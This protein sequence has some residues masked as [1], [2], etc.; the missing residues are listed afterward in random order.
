MRTGKE[1]YALFKSW[2]DESKL[3]Q[4]ESL[5]FIREGIYSEIIKFSYTTIREKNKLI[6]NYVP[7]SAICLRI[8]PDG[9]VRQIFDCLLEEMRAYALRELEEQ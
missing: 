9:M 7:V 5:E 6:E 3:N 4:N 2:R 1:L 8:L